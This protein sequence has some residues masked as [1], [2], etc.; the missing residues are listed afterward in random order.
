MSSSSTYRGMSPVEIVHLYLHEVPVVFLLM[1]EQPVECTHITMIG[2]TQMAYASSLSLFKKE[3]E[4]VVVEE[5]TSEVVH[6]SPTNTVQKVIVYVID[7]QSLKRLEVH[8]FGL[9]EVP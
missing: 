8:L 1:V 6:P 7:S 9:I 4:E 5:T 3:F 2:E